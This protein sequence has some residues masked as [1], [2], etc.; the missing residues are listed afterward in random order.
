MQKI[1]IGKQVTQDTTP[2]IFTTPFDTMVDVSTNLIHG[3]RG[4]RS[5][6]ANHPD[7]PPEGKED[8]P[9]EYVKHQFVKKLVWEKDFDDSMIVG[10]TRLGL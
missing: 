4:V 10:F 3:D 2:F 1:I 7:I 9:D 5:L 8:D 6:I